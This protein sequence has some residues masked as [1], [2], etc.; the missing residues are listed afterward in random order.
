MGCKFTR[1]NFN[2]A[3]GETWKSPNG[4]PWGELEINADG[5]PLFVNIEKANKV[6]SDKGGR[7]PTQEEWKELAACFDGFKENTAPLRNLNV[8]KT[9]SLNGNDFLFAKTFNTIDKK[10][11]QIP[12]YAQE[13]GDGW[14]I[15]DNERA[16]V[17]CV[18]AH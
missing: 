8:K 12:R 11:S 15:D 1:D 5:S 18:G 3:L 7:L 9:W 4:V 13:Q 16:F 6:C 2:P 14:V 17:R 10:F